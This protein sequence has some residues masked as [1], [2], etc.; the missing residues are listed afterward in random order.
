M[1]RSNGTSG[2]TRLKFGAHIAGKLAQVHL[3]PRLLSILGVGAVIVTG[4]PILGSAAPADGGFFIYSYNRDDPQIEALAGLLGP[5]GPELPGGENPGGE[6]PNQSFVGTVACGA[7]SS[8]V[9]Q[10]ML[11][12]SDKNRELIASG[13]TA[14]PWPDGGW[15]YIHTGSYY[16]ALTGQTLPMAADSDKAYIFSNDPNANDSNYLALMGDWGPQVWDNST[17]TL[18]GDIDYAMFDHAN[19]AKPSMI[20]ELKVE[21][22]GSKIEY[23]SYSKFEKGKLSSST[24]APAYYQ[25]Q[26]LFGQPPATVAVYA[27]DGL[28]AFGE[29]RPSYVG[30]SYGNK[31]EVFYYPSNGERWKYH[32]AKTG[33]LW[34]QS[35]VNTTNQAG[36]ITK[37]DTWTDCYGLNC[38]IRYP[39]PN[40]MLS[41]Q[42]TSEWD[43]SEVTTK[44]YSVVDPLPG[45]YTHLRVK[46]RE[47]GTIFNQEYLTLTGISPGDTR[48]HRTDGPANYMEDE[49][50]KLYRANYYLNG[51]YIGTKA[52][53]ENAGG[54]GWIGLYMY[55]ESEPLG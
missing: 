33:S 1:G 5:G 48:L 27:K 2:R 24:A 19:G 54:T 43:G 26:G 53:Y 50:G 9:T 47:N 7:E 18:V 6:N 10:E 11:D 42:T 49:N 22:E 29:D 25:S 45:G 8:T 12:W 38:E 28:P 16:K 35:R 21:A 46:L 32:D 31:T 44:T 41:S 17:K 20:G 37:T 3:G 23:C 13:D 39:T 15:T 40:V 55:G 52:D 34:H 4:A 30:A 14:Q 51:Q 36:E